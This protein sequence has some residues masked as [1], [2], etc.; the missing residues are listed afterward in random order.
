MRNIKMTISYDGTS[1]CGFQIQ[2]NQVTIQGK[3]EEA[4]RILTGEQ[5]KITSSGRTDAGVHARG[6]VI[7]YTTNSRIPIDRW[8]LALNS[9]LPD[10]ITVHSAEEAPL[11]FHA[12]HGARE[13]TYRYSIQRSKWPDVFQQKLRLHHPAP[14]DV[15]AMRRALLRLEGEHDFT[16]F[17]STRTS[18]ESHVRTIYS[19]SVDYVPEPMIADGEAGVIHIY[20]TGNGFLYNMVRIIVGT[21]IE[22]GSGKRAESEMSD[23]LAA[24][25]RSLA[26]PTAMPHGLTLWE[27][28][29]D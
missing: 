26:G 28:K 9:R 4:V 24:R 2:P 20:I 18:V 22:V 21:L 8:C 1:Y 15:E 13:K 25:D 19:T 17:C 14:L 5:V 12:R 11:D 3:L 6:Q 16:S 7:N 10:D 29:Y 27:V 23:I